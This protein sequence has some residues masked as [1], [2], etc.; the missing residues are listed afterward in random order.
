MSF[1]Y[2]WGVDGLP[3]KVDDRPCHTKGISIEFWGAQARWHL[4][5]ALTFKDETHD[6]WATEQ[7][8]IQYSAVSTQ[9][10]AALAA[11]PK[12]YSV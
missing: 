1:K 10:L 8:E 5:W 7:V 6:E 2:Q 9:P 4:D 3:R 12:S 11:L